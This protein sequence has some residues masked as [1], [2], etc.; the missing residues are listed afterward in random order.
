MDRIYWDSFKTFLKVGAFTFGG[1]Y[2]MIPII[3]NEVVEKHKWVSREEFIDLIA[4]AQ[5]CPGV[6]AINISTFIGYKLRR[7]RGAICSALGTA[8]RSSS[9]CSS[10]CAS[11]ASWTWGG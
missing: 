6:F 3:E 9:S 2:A 5:S 11:T 10:L 8:L 1:G 4:V 7:E